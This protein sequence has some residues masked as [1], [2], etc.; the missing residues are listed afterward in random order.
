MTAMPAPSPAG[1]SFEMKI[2]KRHRIF[3]EKRRS[4][5]S[6]EKTNRI[7]LAE[8]LLSL[9]FWNRVAVYKRYDEYVD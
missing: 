6:R 5:A 8:A 9:S 2:K 7:A 1:R 3:I 4:E